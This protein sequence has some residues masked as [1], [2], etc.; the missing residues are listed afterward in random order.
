MATLTTR[1]VTNVSTGIDLFVGNVFSE[2]V[3]DVIVR[4]FAAFDGRA[5]D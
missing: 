2:D 1:A 3:I 5:G 4:C